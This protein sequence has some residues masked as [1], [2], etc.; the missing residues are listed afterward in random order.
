MTVRSFLYRLGILAL[1]WGAL[2]QALASAQTSSKVAA[3]ALFEDGRKLVREGKIAEACPKFADSQ[4]LDP[5]S[6]TLLN[7]ASCWEKLG[8]TASAWAT[9]KEAASAAA[10]SGRMDYRTAAERHA[11]VLE[12]KLARLTVDVSQPVDGLEVRRDGVVVDRAEWGVGIPVDTGSHTLSAAAPGRVSW[13]SEVQVAQDG[14]QATL[15]VPPLEPQPQGGASS[16]SASPPAVAPATP[17]ARSGNPAMGLPAAS[18]HG[19]SS[20][21]QRTI[22][23]IVGGVGVAGLAVGAAYAI[24]A[25][26]KYENSLSQCQPSDKNLCSP[27]GVA[28]R[29]DARWAGDAAT[30]ALSIGAAAVVAG[31]VLWLTAPSGTENGTRAAT[32]ARPLGMSLS[33]VPAP[34]GALLRGTW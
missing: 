7:L 29:D 6:A 25:H 16:S 11:S 34:V 32:A 2:P 28:Q 3:E 15:T 5:S 26:T 17:L 20:T 23:W 21:T 30:V 13:T 19:S 8:R 18:S 1:V 31:G 33:I 10:A 24:A 27:Q 12:P 22:G 9:Y 14:A 4:R